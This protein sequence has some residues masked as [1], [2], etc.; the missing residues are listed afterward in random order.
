[1]KPD[2]E[3]LIKYLTSLL[4]IHSPSGGEAQCAFFLQQ[5]F[6]EFGASID[7][8]GN[9]L[10]KIPG[11]GE[12]ILLC[13][14]MD[15]VD[16]SDEIAVVIENGF[17]RNAKPYVLGIDNKSTIA[18]YMEAIACLKESDA[19]H[20]PIELLFTVAEETTSLG[21]EKVDLALFSAK[22]A[23]IVDSALPVG[24]IITESP[25][26]SNLN[27]HISGPTHHTKKLTAGEK[28]AWSVLQS[29]IAL[30]PHG[31]IDKSTNVNWANVEGGFGRNTVTGEFILRGEIRSF[32]KS[33]CEAVI[34]QI[35]QSIQSIGSDQIRFV[36]ELINEGYQ[37]EAND[38]WLATVVDSLKQ[39]GVAE[40][41]HV[42]DHGVSDAN[43]LNVRGTHTLNIS[44]GA[45]HTHTKDE[46]I[47]VDD[48]L[49]ITNTVITLCTN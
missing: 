15:V 24:G 14:H 6:A 42:R 44:G 46:T 2:S 48:L 38:T 29:L 20:R 28:T 16:P 40:I 35:E 19:S 25:F 4:E 33:V 17:V 13:A 49:R 31:M 10:V 26:Y 41:I 34:A 45:Q 37:I 5:H 32:N 7:A 30:L 47:A 3:R 22:N 9:V 43:I 11:T 21:A 8:T 23:L 12:P 1:M 27:I 39:N 36:Y 18:C